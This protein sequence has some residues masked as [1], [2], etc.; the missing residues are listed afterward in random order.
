MHHE[1]HPPCQST[2]NRDM[3]LSPVFFSETCCFLFPHPPFR[4]SFGK[5]NS[6]EVDLPNLNI[7]I[8]QFANCWFTILSTLRR[9]V[10]CSS[11]SSNWAEVMIFWGKAYPPKTSGKWISSNCHCKILQK[12]VQI[13]VCVYLSYLSSYLYVFFSLR[14]SV[15]V[16]FSSQTSL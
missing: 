13:I 12:Q 9:A 11:E 5:F 10:A 3:D 16:S 15:F 7:V 4:C 8:F 6:I 14:L 1:G 2:L